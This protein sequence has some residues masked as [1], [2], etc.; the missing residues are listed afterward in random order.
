MKQTGNPAMQQRG[1]TFV[2]LIITVVV[3][4]IALGGIVLIYTTTVAG[5]A[6]PMRRE[7]AIAV[8]ESYLDEILSRRFADPDG[9]DGEGV[10]SNF[11]DVDDYD[12][13]NAE[14]PTDM[15][16]N[17]VAGLGDYSVNVVVNN[18]GVGGLAG[19][20]ESLRVDVIVSYDNESITISGYRTNY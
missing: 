7:Q 19:G 8:A 6:N 10:R 11:D 17:P 13:I 15:N 3:L 5:S 9:S 2:E 16:G 14:V 20:S 12:Q 18:A 4:G 1:F